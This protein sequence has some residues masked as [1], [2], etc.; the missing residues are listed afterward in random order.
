[1]NYQDKSGK[2]DNVSSVC[3]NMKDQYIYSCIIVL[4]Y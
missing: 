3:F 2:Y 4:D 1:M